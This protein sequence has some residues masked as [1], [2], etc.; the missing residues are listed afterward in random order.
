M[1]LKTFEVDWNPDFAQNLLASSSNHRITNVTQVV[2]K[3][4]FYST[5]H[6]DSEAHRLLCQSFQLRL[7]R[8]LHGK[9]YTPESRGTI[10]PEASYDQERGNPLIR[11]VVLLRAVADTDLLPPNDFFRLKVSHST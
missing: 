4:K 1:S 10:V 5:N 9:G 7:I 3:L 2:T 8:W 6:N 11:A